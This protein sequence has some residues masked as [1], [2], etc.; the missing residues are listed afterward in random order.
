MD[1]RIQELVN[2]TQEKWGLDNYFLHTSELYQ[3]LTESNE[4]IYTLNMEWFPNHHK[5]WNDE[6]ENPEGTASID[7]NIHTRQFESVIFVGGITYVDKVHFPQKDKK[8]IIAWL[9]KETGLQYE[10]QF[11]LQKEETHEW[12]FKGTINGLT[13]CQHYVDAVTG[14][15]GLL[16]D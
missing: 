1:T 9:E 12:I 14:E 6:E 8:E 11:I 13:F 10:Q 16:N 2:L 3:R 15:I 7:I 4:T 5:D